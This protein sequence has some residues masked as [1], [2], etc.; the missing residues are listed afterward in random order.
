MSCSDTITV[1]PAAP[2]A[3]AAEAAQRVPHSSRNTVTPS[4]H[5]L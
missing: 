1:T 3:S 5:T 2:S 4:H